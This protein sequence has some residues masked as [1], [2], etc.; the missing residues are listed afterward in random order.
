MIERKHLEARYK[1]HNWPMLLVLDEK[2]DKG[3][4]LIKN[5]DHL[6][7][8]ALVVILARSDDHW[9]SEPSKPRLEAEVPDV[10]LE[11]L[12]PSMQRDAK[13]LKSRNAQEQRRFDEANE[14]WALL[15]KAIAGDTLAAFNVLDN[16]K[17]HEYENWSLEPLTVAPE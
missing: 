2:H 14:D 16:R 8:T 13:T 7:S 3:Y 12:P 4:Y 17:D 1:H 10:V 5:I 15:Q 9:Y 6:L 11:M